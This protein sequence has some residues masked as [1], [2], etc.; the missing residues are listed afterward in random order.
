MWCVKKERGVLAC[1]FCV[2]LAWNLA[3]TATEIPATTASSSASPSV[4]SAALLETPVWDAARVSL[5]HQQAIET[6][7]TLIQLE[8]PYRAEDAA[9]VPITI[10]AG[11]PQNPSQYIQRIYLFIDNNPVPLAATFS[12]TPDSGLADI[13]TRVR[14]NAYTPI[15]AIAQLNDGQLLMS[16]RYIKASGGCSAPVGKDSAAAEARLGKMRLK[17]ATDGDSKQPLLAQ[18][19]I[20]H[21]NNS[22]L[23]LDQISRLYVPA[24]FIK[25]VQV[26]FNDKLIMS[27]ETDIS[28]SEDP[29][30]RFYVQT[31][32]ADGT[33]TADVIDS[34]GAKFTTSQ[35]LKLSSP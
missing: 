22:G 35:V 11:I 8:T 3:V 15:R 23:Q 28:I 26:H 7:Q 16:A 30:F 33:L 24:R 9:I 17:I 27:A 6:N 18:L 19:M 1:L 20:S 5:F 10:K 12:L 2:C 31:Q 4:T 32:G 13:A 29:S 14:I 34:T 21:P 25:Q